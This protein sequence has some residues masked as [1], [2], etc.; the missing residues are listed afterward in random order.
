[1][2]WEDV[3]WDRD[4]E[5]EFGVVP[6]ESRRDICREIGIGGERFA[7]DRVTEYFLGQNYVKDRE[8]GEE[9]WLH[10]D[11]ESGGSQVRI[12]YPDSRVYHQAGW[13]IQV[14]VTEGGAGEDYYLEVKTHTA[15]SVRGKE[16]YL[17]NEQ[18]KAAARNRDRYVV[19]GVIY[20]YRQRRGERILSF[21]DPVR[22]IGDGRMV[23]RQK[24]YVFWLS[25]DE[26][27]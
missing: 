12:F 23:N 1:M 15:G 6:E 4:M 13:D 25:P 2:A 16:M 10:R 5:E 11:G 22:C 20:N 18:M 8:S 17:S 9:I 27:G 26:A 24:G 3:A 19:L 7:L 14:T 21:P